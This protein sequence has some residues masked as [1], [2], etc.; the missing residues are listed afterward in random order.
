MSLRVRQRHRGWCDVTGQGGVTAGWCGWRHGGGVAS[1]RV[2]AALRWHP[3]SR[4]MVSPAPSLGHSWLR[5]HCHPHLSSPDSSCCFLWLP[6]TYHPPSV[7]IW[8]SLNCFTQ[9]SGNFIPLL[10]WAATSKLT[11]L[12]N[13]RLFLP[14]LVAMVRI[15]RASHWDVLPCRKLLCLG[16]KPQLYS[17]PPLQ[18]WGLNLPC[19]V[20][21]KCFQGPQWDTPMDLPGPWTDLQF[22]LKIYTHSLIYVY[23]S[24]ISTQLHTERINL[25]LLFFIHI[26]L[27]INSGRFLK[28]TISHWKRVWD[29][30]QS[31]GE[32]QEA[33]ARKAGTV[34]PITITL[35]RAPMLPAHVCEPVCGVGSCAPLGRSGGLCGCP[36]CASMGARVW[37]GAPLPLASGLGLCPALPLAAEAAE[38]TAAWC[39]KVSSV[40]LADARWLCGVWTTG[41]RCTATVRSTQTTGKAT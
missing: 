17:P 13:A 2:A 3:S 1:P 16:F 10:A 7:L 21:T 20:S 41:A 26:S 25:L 37:G 15:H 35:P 8:N 29:P 34:V 22:L 27:D 12:V 40:Q 36:R 32:L 5:L 4:C 31:H 24:K 14:M 9:S 33:A 30:A 18:P 19:P 6:K 38:V 11:A 39:G 23:N 28:W